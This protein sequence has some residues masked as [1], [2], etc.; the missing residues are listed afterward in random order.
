MIE[1]ELASSDRIM[2][3]LTQAGVAPFFTSKDLQR[4][5]VQLPIK[6]HDYYL[7]IL[8]PWKDLSYAGL[9]E[10]SELG[11]IGRS[12]VRVVSKA[13]LVKLKEL[14]VQHLESEAGKHRK[15][16]QWLTVV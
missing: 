15:D 2:R 8:T 9:R 1:P 4:P 7:D 12:E 13:D 6:R 5:K 11:V 3:A 10:R 16:L 14:V